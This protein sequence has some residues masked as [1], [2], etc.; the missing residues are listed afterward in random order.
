MQLL[1]DLMN[2]EKTASNV[3]TSNV[4]PTASTW[5]MTAVLFSKAVVTQQGHQLFLH[6][7]ELL[8][9]QQKFLPLYPGF[10]WVA[11]GSHR[12]QRHCVNPA[13][14]ASSPNPYVLKRQHVSDKTERCAGSHPCPSPNI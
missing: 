5:Y 14:I 7:L 9:I 8:Y 3:P 1:A 6:C 13:T 11:A 4:S 12:H 2:V 10:C